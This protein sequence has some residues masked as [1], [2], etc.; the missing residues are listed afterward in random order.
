MTVRNIKHNFV[1][2]KEMRNKKLVC[3]NNYNKWHRSEVVQYLRDNQLLSD[4]HTSYINGPQHLQAQNISLGTNLMQL[5]QNL[6]IIL[7]SG[8]TAPF[9]L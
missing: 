4:T 9:I 8:K 2:N 6:L 5:K 1:A 7:D 3:L